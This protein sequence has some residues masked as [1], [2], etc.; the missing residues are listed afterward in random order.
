VCVCVCVC[1]CAIWASTTH[2]SDQ[3]R[4]ITQNCQ[5]VEA[6]AKDTTTAIGIFVEASKDQECSGHEP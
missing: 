3:L 1:V 2:R 5:A 4:A 6:Q